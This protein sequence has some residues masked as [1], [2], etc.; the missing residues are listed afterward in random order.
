MGPRAGHFRAGA[1]EGVRRDR[2]RTRSA[3]AWVPGRQ[4]FMHFEWLITRGKF[5]PFL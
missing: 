4:I 3:L 5:I 1:H 2:K